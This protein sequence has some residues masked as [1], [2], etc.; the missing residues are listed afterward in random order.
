MSNP[1]YRLQSVLTEN[2]QNTA[3]GN[4]IVCACRVSWNFVHEEIYMCMRVY[5]SYISP[6]YPQTSRELVMDSILFLSWNH[7]G[8]VWGENTACALWCIYILI[9]L[10]LS[11]ILSTACMSLTSLCSSVVCRAVYLSVITALGLQL[12]LSSL[13][14]T[15]E[16]GERWKYYWVHTTYSSYTYW[17]LWKLVC[18]CGIFIITDVQYVLLLYNGI[19][20]T[21]KVASFVDII[22]TL[23][24][25][26]GGSA[27]V[28]G[29]GRV[30]F[31]DNLILRERAALC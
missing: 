5:A 19:S 18:T 4:K 17:S 16:A 28:R 14:Q 29:E 13:Y 21:W 6:L 1:H 12:N 15:E 8:Y 11:I 23:Y 10:H 20:S 27:K 31:N 2:T 30:V 22:N 24:I 25:S 26:H 9:Y 7:H 3:W